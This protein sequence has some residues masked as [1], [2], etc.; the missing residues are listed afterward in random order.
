ML[1]E[2][3]FDMYRTVDYCSANKQ[4]LS[5]IGILRL[6]IKPVRGSGCCTF[7]N[8]RLVCCRSNKVSPSYSASSH[9]LTQS[10]RQQSGSSSGTMGAA[11][12]PNSV[13]S[14]M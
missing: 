6:K 5:G 13:V 9:A 8:Q 1:T 10:T 7:E 3:E 14:F 2:G 12:D 4:K 11:Q